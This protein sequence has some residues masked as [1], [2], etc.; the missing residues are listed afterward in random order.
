MKLDFSLKIQKK[1]FRPD[2]S[3]VFRLHGSNEKAKRLLNW[4]PHY[5]GKKGFVKAI[6]ETY[7][8]YKKLDNLKL[9]KDTYSI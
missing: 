6:N 9:F 2:K 3:E 8:W 7:Q 5:F 1:R 4:K